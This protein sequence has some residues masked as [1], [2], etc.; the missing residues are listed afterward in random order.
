MNAI[1]AFVFHEKNLSYARSLRGESL[2]FALNENSR[3]ISQCLKRYTNYS[4]SIS[5]PFAK[6]GIKTYLF[7]G[8]GGV[9]LCEHNKI[10]HVSVSI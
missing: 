8:G 9:T 7:C 6:N 3:F 4:N 2:L 1:R 10:I 5:H